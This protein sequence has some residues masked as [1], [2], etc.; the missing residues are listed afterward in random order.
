MFCGRCL[1]NRESLDECLAYTTGW[2][3]GLLSPSGC[4]SGGRSGNGVRGSVSELSLRDRSLR[5]VARPVVVRSKE[6]SG[7]WGYG[8]IVPAYD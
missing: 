3:S 6:F 4:P 5:R 1:E 8:L 7:G 2:V